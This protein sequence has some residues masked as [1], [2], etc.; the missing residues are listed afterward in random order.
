MMRTMSDFGRTTMTGG[1]MAVITGGTMAVI[2][3]IGI[4]TITIT[5]PAGPGGRD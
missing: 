2:S 4:T 3:I 5:M 1:T